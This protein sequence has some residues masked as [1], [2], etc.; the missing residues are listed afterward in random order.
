MYYNLER[1]KEENA[2]RYA[3]R[4][5]KREKYTVMKN[6]TRKGYYDTKGGQEKVT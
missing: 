2:H 1:N 3:V 6:I 5:K 4:G